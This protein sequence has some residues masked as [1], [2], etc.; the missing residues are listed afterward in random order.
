MN[1]WVL[2][3]CS[4]YK[5]MNMVM[6]SPIRPKSPIAK[7]SLG[8]VPFPDSTQVVLKMRYAHQSGTHT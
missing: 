2:P 1:I 8:R 7:K 6:N 5:I 3:V 4:Y